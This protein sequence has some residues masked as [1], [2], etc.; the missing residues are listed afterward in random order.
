LGLTLTLAHELQHFVQH[1]DQRRLWAA[2]SLIPNLTN[3]T[4]EELGL[5]WCDLP[6]EREARIVSKKVA[7]KL[8]GTE[9][10]RSFI[11]VKIAECL[12]AAD[13]DDWHC[14][15]GLVTSTAYDLASETKL[16]FPRLRPYRSQLQDV[17]G[18]FQSNDADFADID[19]VTLLDATS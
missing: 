18:H 6:H 11:D 5:R 12:T 2:N 19:L 7:E 13:A 10:V 3:A 1:R 17:L 9:A 14:I 4:I 16:F 8:F 15:Q